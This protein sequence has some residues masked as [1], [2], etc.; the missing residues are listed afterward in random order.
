MLGGVF[1]YF[2]SSITHLDKLKELALGE[3]TWDKRNYL[4]YTVMG[5]VFINGDGPCFKIHHTITHFPLPI[6]TFHSDSL[7]NKCLESFAPTLCEAVFQQCQ[8]F[9]E[10]AKGNLYLRKSVKY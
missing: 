8:P 5:L 1:I 7:K 3:V 9:L 10:I 2:V 4:E 6:D